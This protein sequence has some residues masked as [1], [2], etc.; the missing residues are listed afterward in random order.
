MSYFGYVLSDK[1][2]QPDPKKN[3]AIQEMKPPNE[4]LLGMVSYLDKFTPNL[5][6]TMHHTHE[7]VWDD[8][9]QTAFDMKLLITSGGPLVYYDVNKEVTLKVDAS[10]HSLGALLMREGKPVAHASKSLRCFDTVF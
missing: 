1:E 2:V 9:E 7:F 3:A 5:A 6:E 10:K 4:T 8:A